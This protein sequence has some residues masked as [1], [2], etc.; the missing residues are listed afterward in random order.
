MPAKLK[1]D[2][3]VHMYQALS[4]GSPN[5]KQ[6][7]LTIVGDVLEESGYEASPASVIPNPVGSAARKIMETITRKGDG[8]N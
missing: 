7:A 4:E 5:R 1:R 2:Q 6:I 3:A 8:S